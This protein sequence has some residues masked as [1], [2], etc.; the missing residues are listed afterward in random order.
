MANDESGGEC[1]EVEEIREK[2]NVV[3]LLGSEEI[4]IRKILKYHKI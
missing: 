3:K 4:S 2:V 1:S